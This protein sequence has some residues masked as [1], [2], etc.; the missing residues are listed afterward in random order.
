M[1]HYRKEIYK[2]KSSNRKRKSKQKASFRCR[3]REMQK[4]VEKA[5]K[6]PLSSYDLHM[7]TNREPNFLGIFASNEL[8][9][10]RII[11]PCVSFIVNLDISSE[12]GSH[13]IAIRIGRTR[14]EV[15]DSLGFTFKLWDKYPQHLITF[16]SRYARSHSFFI[17]P[18]LQPPNSFTCGLFCAFYIIYRQNHSFN[19]CIK[20]FTRD[21][22]SNNFK[23]FTYM[24]TLVN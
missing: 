11:R 16:L 22:S 2:D 1:D 12:P 3:R 13:W 7:L 19:N 20:K 4:V 17:S 10:L 23:L 18:I 24:D 5:K 15:F 9:T 21:I 6:A 8:E 14:V